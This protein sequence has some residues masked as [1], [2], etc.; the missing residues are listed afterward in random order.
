MLENALRYFGEASGSQWVRKIFAFTRTTVLNIANFFVLSSV[1][2]HLSVPAANA[3][4]CSA[5]YH[6]S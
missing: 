4:Q 2:T 3:L 1:K 5:R 6:N